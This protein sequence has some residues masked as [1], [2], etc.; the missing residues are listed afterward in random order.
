MRTLE[1]RASDSPSG[2]WH[3]E[4][5][6]VRLRC[7]YDPTPKATVA[8]LIASYD[9][10]PEVRRAYASAIVLSRGDNMRHAPSFR[11]HPFGAQGS[12]ER[13]AIRDRFKMR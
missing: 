13:G 8:E 4:V 2:A 6:P 9:Q 11:E 10:H 7:G 3:R 1:F 12:R 5:N